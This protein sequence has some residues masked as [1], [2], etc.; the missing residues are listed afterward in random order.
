MCIKILKN[1]LKC[2]NK[3]KKSEESEKTNQYCHIHKNKI[4]EEGL[5][6]KNN[7]L[8]NHNII[9]LIEIEKI[10]ELNNNFKKEIINLNKTVE[11]KNK[12]ISFKNIE[13]NTFK[14][15]NNEL[16]KSIENKDEHIKKFKNK[17]INKENLLMKYINEIEL[18]KED[19]DKFQVIKKFEI[20]KDN[21]IKKGINVRKY[22]NQEY[23]RLRYERNYIV[24]LS[25]NSEKSEKS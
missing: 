17:L 8:I 2:K 20:Y 15:N 11:K 3:C 18:M 1:G 12:I 21:L 14:K 6:I 25:F 7:K 24:H 13:L 19:Y 16:F 10:K 4:Q 23:N 9:L 22:N 5:E